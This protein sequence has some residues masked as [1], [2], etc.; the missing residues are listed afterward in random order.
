MITK[1]IVSI[2]VLL[3]S[4]SRLYSN[5]GGDGTTA[6]SILVLLDSASRP[7][8]ELLVVLPQ[9]RFNPCSSG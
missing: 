3:D 5:G 2:L 4:A 9:Y 1:I 7:L 6:V 8:Q